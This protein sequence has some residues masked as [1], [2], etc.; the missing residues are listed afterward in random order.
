MGAAYRQ[1]LN[2]DGSLVDVKLTNSIIGVIDLGYRT[3]DLCQ[4]NQLQFMSKLSKSNPKLGCYSLFVT[5]AEILRQKG[6][7]DKEP[8]YYE[9]R[10]NQDG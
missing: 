7:L 6:I 10:F 8:E 2:S 9:S 5:L 1:L 4:L 3:K